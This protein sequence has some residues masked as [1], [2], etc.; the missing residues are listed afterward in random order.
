MLKGRGVED[1][2]DAPHRSNNS[3]VITD[4]TDPEVQQLPR[5]QKGSLERWRVIFLQEMQP[6]IV[7]LRLVTGEDRH[8][9]RAS[10]LPCEDPLHQRLPK[11]T[12][13]SGHHDPLSVQFSHLS[14]LYLHGQ[15]RWNNKIIALSHLPSK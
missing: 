3:G 13:T 10:H 6:H 15:S 1:H 9:L 5:I 14:C 2:I 4:V 12:S 11:R 7:L 8:R